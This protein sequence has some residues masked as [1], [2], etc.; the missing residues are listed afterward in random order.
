MKV[1]FI[2]ALSPPI[3]GQSVAS[4]T[5]LEELRQHHRV[6]LV[7]YSKGTLR[8]G[9]TSLSRIVQACRILRQVRIENRDAEAIYLTLSQSI[10]GNLKDLIIYAICFDKLENMVVH[11]HGGGIKRVLF[12]KHPI[13]RWLN[14][15]FLKRVGAAVV[16]GQSLK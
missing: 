4:E 2:A 3:T 10:A 6:R 9:I 15:F 5:L 16:L 14:R 8:Q 12:D 13:F 11:L 7:D 1:L